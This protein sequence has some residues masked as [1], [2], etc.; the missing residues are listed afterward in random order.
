MK[1]ESD[2]GGN[3]NSEAK[4]YLVKNFRSPIRRRK[5]VFKLVHTDAELINSRK[6]S[7]EEKRKRER[8]EWKR[9]IHESKSFIKNMQSIQREIQHKQDDQLRKLIKRLSFENKVL[10]SALVDQMA[11]ERGKKRE[12]TFESLK[13]E[14]QAIHNAIKEFTARSKD[15]SKKLNCRVPSLD[16]RKQTLK[17]KDLKEKAHEL[18]EF[19]SRYLDHRKLKVSLKGRVLSLIHICRCRRYAVC[20]SRW[21]PYH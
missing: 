15:M 9:K 2:I 16:N 4:I 14:Q 17:D 7:Y 8:E 5:Q 13:R 12:I 6:K 1:N 11:N 19:F 21:S 10:D 20:R 18:E 3:I